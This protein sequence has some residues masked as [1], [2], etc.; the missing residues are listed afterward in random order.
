MSDKERRRQELNEALSA[1]LATFIAWCKATTRKVPPDHIIE[2]TYHQLRSCSL[3]QP[4]PVRSASK[5]WLLDHNYH[6]W[7]DGDVPT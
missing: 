4:M 2:I 7:D 5:R 6:S 1:D 3:R